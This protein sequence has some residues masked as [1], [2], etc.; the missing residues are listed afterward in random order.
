MYEGAQIIKHHSNSMLM[1]DRFTS[2]KEKSSFLFELLSMILRALRG[3][4]FSTVFDNINHTH[5]I[6][7]RLDH[8]V[9]CLN[10]P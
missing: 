4:K 10:P 1:C 2:S 3:V 6:H 5:F 9:D 7:K 8:L